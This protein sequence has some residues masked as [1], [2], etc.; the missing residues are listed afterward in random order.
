MTPTQMAKRNRM[1]VLMAFAAVYLVWGS[2][3]L[4]I[5][6]AIETIPP[7]L[8]G[9]SRYF[10]AGLALYGIAL[11][12]K[13]SRPSRTEVRLGIITGLL[14][15]GLGNG[16]VIW[17]EQSVSSSMTALIVSMVPLWIV[18]IDWLRPHGKRPAPLMF[19]GLGL[20][21]IGM[22]VL[23]G[24]GSLTGNGVVPVAGMLVLFVGSVGWAIGTLVTRRGTKAS[25]PMLFSAIQMLAAGVGF[26]IMSVAFGEPGRFALSQVSMK[27]WLSV[28]YLVL[29]GSIV[30]YTAYVYL[31]RHT[32]AAKAATYAYVNP[33]IAVLLGWLFANE[34]VTARTLVAAMILLAG[35]AIIT[36]LQT[37]ASSHTDEHPIPTPSRE[38]ERSAA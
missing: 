11:A 36:S 24:P 25:S 16:G 29:G 14:M 15:P 12:R 35:V 22:I 17:A 23:V 13:A 27:S 30:A 34:T 5:R 10:I 26:A 37:G 33:V 7:F 32:S 4:F 3:Y 6:Y 19:V 8:L 31:I 18:L 21:L 38:Q 9:T 28:A 1:R 2:T 20:G